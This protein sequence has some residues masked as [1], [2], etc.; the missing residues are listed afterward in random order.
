M[1]RFD[2]LRTYQKCEKCETRV[3]QLEMRLDLNS[4]RIHTYK[5]YLARKGNP[6]FA[7]KC[8][9]FTVRLFVFRFVGKFRASNG[10]IVE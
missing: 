4:I 2:L 6:I 8:D 9:R 1:L 3:S 7:I 5:T 10:S